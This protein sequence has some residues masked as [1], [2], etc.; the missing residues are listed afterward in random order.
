VVVDD[1]G[2]GRGVGR[3]VDGVGFGVNTQLP[4]CRTVNCEAGHVPANDK[5][6]PLDASVPQYTHPKLAVHAS[7]PKRLGHGAGAAGVG[8]FGVGLGVGHEL[9]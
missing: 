9:T 2:V 5:Q 4:P 1:A 3:G 7:Q 6:S 8:G